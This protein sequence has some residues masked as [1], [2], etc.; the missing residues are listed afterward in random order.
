MTK[1]PKP[2]SQATIWLF[3]FL[4]VAIAV[5]T[6]LAMQRWDS[7]AYMTTDYSAVTGFNALRHSW[8]IFALIGGIA[9]LIGAIVGTFSAKRAISA[10]RIALHAENERL[11]AHTKQI[12]SAQIRSAELTEQ[13]AR[14]A[15]A[16]ATATRIAAERTELHARE[17][18]ELLEKRLARAEAR[19]SGALRAMAASKAKTKL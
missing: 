18:V 19:L 16:A 9:A 15:V 12:F 11:S 3:L 14:E 1:E 6:Y 7:I 2:K 13:R 4:I 8:P 17:R 10:E 5:L